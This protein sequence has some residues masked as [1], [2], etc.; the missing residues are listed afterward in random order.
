[1]GQHSD[2]WRRQLNSIFAAKPLTKD[3]ARRIAVATKNFYTLLM[4]LSDGSDQQ[5]QQTQRLRQANHGNAAAYH[6]NCPPIMSQRRTHCLSK[7]IEEEPN[8]AC[9]YYQ[10]Q[11]SNH[12]SED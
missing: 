4:S 2:Y 7:Q 5:N 10:A 3:E 1:L 12:V 9:N 11:H 8:S 6:A